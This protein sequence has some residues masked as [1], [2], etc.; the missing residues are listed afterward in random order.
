LQELVALLPWQGITEEDV[1]NGYGCDPAIYFGESQAI[2]SLCDEGM[3]F[4]YNDS[5]Q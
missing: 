5:P 1:R 2:V 4:V 3:G